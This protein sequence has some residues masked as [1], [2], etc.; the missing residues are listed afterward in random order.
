MLN[1]HFVM[2]SVDMSVL[3]I[4]TVLLDT[5]LKNKNYRLKVTDL[6]IRIL[7]IFLRKQEYI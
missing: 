4:D 5:K 1:F 6:E 3:V 2:H 7:W